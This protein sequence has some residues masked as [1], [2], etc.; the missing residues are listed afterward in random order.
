MIVVSIIFKDFHYLYRSADTFFKTLI[1][2]TSNVK[3]EKKMYG[4]LTA[5]YLL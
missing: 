5:R 3:I 4:L 2:G 1:I